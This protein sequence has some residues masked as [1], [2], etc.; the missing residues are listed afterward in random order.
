VPV[1]AEAVRRG[2][3]VAAGIAWAVG[4]VTQ[5]AGAQYRHPVTTLDWLAVWSFTG[6]WLLL[7][8]AIVLVGSLAPRRSVFAVAG[9]IALGAVVAGIANAIED[10][11]G[12]RSWGTPY[13][14]GSV[15]ALIGMVVLPAIVARAGSPR[16]ARWCVGLV[17][18][19]CLYAAGGGLA[20]LVLFAWLAW[21]PAAGA[22]VSEPEPVAA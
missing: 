19:M 6:A 4:S 1:L 14:L 10:G 17:V 18:S 8:P 12:I 5:L 13:V 16:L 20:V 7:A 22:A 21:R 2:L 9:V 15:T 11:V 3:W